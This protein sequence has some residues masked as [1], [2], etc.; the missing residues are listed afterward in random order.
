MAIEQRTSQPFDT[1]SKIV[2]D[3]LRNV[4]GVFI[5]YGLDARLVGSLGRYASVYQD[6]PTLDSI[7]GNR[8]I[9]DIDIMLV[10]ANR[11][12]AKEA[13]DVAE[14][15]AYPC[16]VDE[17]FANVVVFNGDGSSLRYKD[18]SVPVESLVFERR[19]G[20]TLGV[21]VPTLNPST[22]FHL[23]EFSGVNLKLF[24]NLH[25][26]LRLIRERQDLLPEA[27]FSPFHQMYDL[28]RES[29]PIEMRIRKIRRVYHKLVPEEIRDRIVPV[30][31]PV[32]HVLENLL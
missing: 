12:R 7:G 5:D 20:E 17:H 23:T 24:A 30:T 2:A 19:Q 16:R 8:G 3:R 10:G 9:K 26:F 29:Y 22:L 14:T 28:Q 6:P 13:L 1:K 11:A 32:R 25:A 15:V 4:F 18:L 27:L 31:R 21:E